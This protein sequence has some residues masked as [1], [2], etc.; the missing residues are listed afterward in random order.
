MIPTKLTLMAYYF[1]GYGIPFIITGSTIL[2]SLL[3]DK[4]YYIRSEVFADD[5][6][7]MSDDES[8]NESA[9]WLDVTIISWVFVLPVALI[10]IFNIF[11]TVA[12]AY[13]AYEANKAR[14]TSQ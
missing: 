7:S 8:A 4:Q 3:T 13:I 5:D 14:K 6:E 10:L 9:C 12:V 1:L 2:V 11:V